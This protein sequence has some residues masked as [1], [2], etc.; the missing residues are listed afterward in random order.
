[1]ARSTVVAPTR[2]AC[3][4]SRTSRHR[5]GQPDAAGCS[6]SMRSNMFHPWHRDLVIAHAMLFSASSVMGVPWAS[7][8]HVLASSHCC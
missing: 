4:S 6:S 3:F 7:Q 2:G 5:A 1:M 8:R